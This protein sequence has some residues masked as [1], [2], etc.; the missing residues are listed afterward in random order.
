MRSWPLKFLN[1]LNRNSQICIFTLPV[2]LN[3]LV[4]ALED[5]EKL[6]RDKKKERALKRKRR[7][8]KTRK[9]EESEG[10]ESALGEDGDDKSLD[11]TRNI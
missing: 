8:D 9:E 2:S 4:S 6:A 10:E 5:L 1:I 7:E 3:T 11:S